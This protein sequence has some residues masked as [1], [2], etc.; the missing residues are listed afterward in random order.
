MLGFL[1]YPSWIR[2]EIIPGFPVRW[3]GLMYIVAFV[4]A[5]LLFRYQI[6]ER[7]LQVNED[8]VVNLFFWGIIGLLIGGRL[9]GT[10]VYDPTGRYL[11][12]PWLIFWPFDETG[13]FVGLAG[14]SYHG[15]LLGGVVAIV[16]FCRA[17]KIDV[18]DW[19][20]M[21]VA[22]VPLGYTFGRLG[23]F[24]NG[25]LWGRVTTL[26]WG[27]YFPGAEPLS[28]KLS[29]VREVAAKAGIPAGAPGSL[30]NLPRHPSQLYEAL[31]EGL[32][33]WLVIWLVFRKRKPFKGFVIA[34]YVIGYGV[35]RF[36]VEY[37]REPDQ[38]IGFPIH[39][40]RLVERAHPAMPLDFSTGQILSFLMIV[41]GIVF[42]IVRLRRLSPKP[43]AKPAS[44]K[45]RRGA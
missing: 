15:G 3:Y 36:I 4:I 16:L 17:R 45:T 13:R 19:G 5:Y 37:F 6:K 9:F 1:N 22:S 42:L 35:I 26:P 25:E 14:M 32:V 33:L 38:G 12:H 11:S 21:L 29:W 8:D 40:Q 41:A 43:D 34:V 24:I 10:L 30:I 2:P 39:F 23:N 44:R 31:F 18:L 7:R 20:D 28:N 27:M